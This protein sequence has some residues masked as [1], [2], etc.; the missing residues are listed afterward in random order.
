M[1]NYDKALKKRIIELKS[2]GKPTTI[3]EKIAKGDCH[4]ELLDKELADT[5]YKIQNTKIDCCRASLMGYQSI[6]KNLDQI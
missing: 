6:N 3:V 1:A 4:K 2:E 5:L